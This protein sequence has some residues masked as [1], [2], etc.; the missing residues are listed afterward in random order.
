MKKKKKLTVFP[1]TNALLALILFPVDAH[2][3]LTLSG[4]VKALYDQGE[5]QLILSHV[6]VAELLEVLDREFPE[7]RGI[8]ES[9]LKLYSH[10]LTRWPTP[11]EVAKVAP[12]AVDSDDAAIFAAAILSQPDIVLSNDFESFHHEKA[13]K[14]WASRKIQLESLYGLLCLFGKRERKSELKQ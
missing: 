8:A 2:G 1:D 12:F 3:K 5:F 7:H 4:D 6:T 11:E 13:K 10:K 9:F 14:L